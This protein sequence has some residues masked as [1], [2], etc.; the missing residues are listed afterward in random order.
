MR[1]STLNSDTVAVAT[2]KNSAGLGVLAILFVAITSLFVFYQQLPPAPLGPDA[3]ANA[4]SSSRAMESLRV[5]AQRPRPIGSLEH[6]AVRTYLIQQ[7]NALGLQTEVQTST[8]DA[9]TIN[10]VVALLKGSGDGPAVL[11][12]AHYDTVVNS[13]GAND[14]GAG[15]ATLLE[16]ARAL[17]ASPPLK[18]DLIFL[19]TDGE[20]RGLLGAIAFVEQHPI[21][22]RAALAL[23][24][25]ARGAG[26]PAVMFETSENNAALI[27]EFA[28]A[29]PYPNAS[30]LSYEIY[31]RLPN[32]TDLTVFKY[33][34][35]AGLN[36]AY[37]DDLNRYHSPSDNVENINEAGLQ[38]H[39]TYALALARHF[40][41]ASLDTSSSGNAIYFDLLGRWLVHY[42]MKWVLPATTLLTILFAA[43]TFFGCKRKRITPRGMIA[44]FFNFIVSAGAALVVAALG[45]AL[46]DTA[47]S[48]SD[49]ETHPSGIYLGVFV[50][51]GI[52]VAVIFYQRFFRKVA[53]ENLA[54]GALVWWLLL[55]IGASIFVPGGSYLLF[56]PLLF[57]LAARFIMFTQNTT[58]SGDSLKTLV[59]QSLLALPGIMLF[60][61]IIYQI[62][63]ALGFF[64]LSIVIPMLMLLFGLLIPHFA[65]LTK[66]NKLA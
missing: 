64:A 48:A 6:A 41:N 34:G 51:L 10:N 18:N 63:A 21:A 49:R 32:N 37:F 53:V 36:F 26:G 17:K 33:A 57:S 35:I 52:A 66:Q 59:L 9:A 27:A 60:V 2:K 3:P 5:I 23:N 28:K 14:D 58:A 46:I 50:L 44:G 24:F 13:P 54:M 38:H 30:S 40:G 22:K 7:L 45:W 39:G 65:L 16:T 56:W 19:F 4:F 15:V 62:F 55:L 1:V 29:A 43:V 20:E 8:R 61:P 31:R 42:S 25:E 11:L 47:K 12:S